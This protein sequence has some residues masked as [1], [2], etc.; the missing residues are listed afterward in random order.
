MQYVEQAVGALDTGDTQKAKALADNA[1]AAA[2]EMR[3][4]PTLI[5]TERS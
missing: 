3:S 1:L 2:P 4:R 5:S